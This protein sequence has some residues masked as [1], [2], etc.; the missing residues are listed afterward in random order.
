MAVQFLSIKFS[1]YWNEYNRG[2]MPRRSGVFCIY[3]AFF[4]DQSKTTTMRELLY[5]G[6]APNVNEC[7]VDHP[8]T[9]RWRACLG[10]TDSLSF[11]FGSVALPDL[12][13]C[14]Q[15]LVMQHR[16]RCNA[17][18]PSVYPFGHVALKLTHRTPLLHTRFTVGS[19]VSGVIGRLGGPL[20]RRGLDFLRSLQPS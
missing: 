14:E 6:A 8:Q 18:V 10:P 13:A 16:P 9:D 1:G 11:S 19:P 2:L 5:V 7:L 15:A 20:L 3:R 4:D 12:V 17:E